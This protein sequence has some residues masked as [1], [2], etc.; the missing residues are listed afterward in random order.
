MYSRNRLDIGW[1]DLF[2]GFYSSFFGHWSPGRQRDLDAMWHPDG[3]TFS[4]V[5]ASWDAILAELALPAGSEVLCSA[6]NIP[7]MFQLLE[8]HGLVAV[9]LE[10]DMETMAV[11]PGVWKHRI[12]ERTRLVLVT[13]LL[14][15]RNNLDALF[16]VAKAHNVPVIEDCAQAFVDH[17]YWGD[18]RALASLFSFGPIKTRS[19]LGGALAI[20]RDVQLRARARE[21]CAAYPRQP[22]RGFLGKVLKYS[23]MKALTLR[24]LYTAFVRGCA[25]LGRSHDQVINGAVLGLKG[26]DYFRVLRT[27]PAIPLLCLLVHRL[28]L[29]K[30]T[31]LGERQQAGEDLLAL[32]P[33]SAPVLGRKAEERSW[34]QFCIVSSD[35]PQMIQHLR[36]QGFD[37]T[38]GSSRLAPVEAGAGYAP[39]TNTEQTMQRVIYVPAYAHMGDKARA[40][41]AAALLA[42]SELLTWPDFIPSGDDHG[43]PR[44]PAAALS[45]PPPSETSR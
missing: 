24:P 38:D 9:P 27:Q 35:P 30:T 43:T 45:E 2:V 7:D 34:W 8:H 41:L 31:A 32:L 13:H 33:E 10:L 37:A 16:S 28:R 23:V 6:V 44:H 22:R 14:G 21:R 5:R 36:D 1:R 19:A 39:A 3:M 17:S 20:I 15:T 25:L 29:T 12:T 18:D 4:T 42:R 40:S 11:P 26:D